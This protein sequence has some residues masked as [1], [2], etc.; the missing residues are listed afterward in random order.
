[1]V[2]GSNQSREKWSQRLGEIKRRGRKTQ[3]AEESGLSS[4]L[5]G[6]LHPLHQ[7]FMMNKKGGGGV[8]RRPC[9]KKDAP[10]KGE[11]KIIDHKELSRERQKLVLLRRIPSMER[12]RDQEGTE[13]QGIKDAKKK[14]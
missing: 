10:A 11:N 1:L 6:V 12:K 5:E 13:A 9:K 14:G 2:R 7:G 3:E 4:K 8:T